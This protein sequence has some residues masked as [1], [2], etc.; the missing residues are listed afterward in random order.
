MGSDLV[1]DGSLGSSP[2]PWDELTRSN[3][4]RGPSVR[5]PRFPPRTTSPGYGVRS[6][7]SMRIRTMPRRHVFTVF[8]PAYG[9][10]E[11]RRRTGQSPRDTR[12]GTWT[13]RSTRLKAHRNRN[14]GRSV[15]EVARVKPGI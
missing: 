15:S 10:D 4:G 1:R 12:A 2:D 5:S 14:R 13:S 3:V 11:P 7:H 6:I 9:C 8:D